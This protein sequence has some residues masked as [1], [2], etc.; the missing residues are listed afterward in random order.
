[1]KKSFYFV[2]VTLFFS[3]SAFAQTE[4][5]NFQGLARN[6]AGEVLVSQQISLRLSVLLG[7]ESGA[8]AYVETRLATTNPQGIFSL[9]VGDGNAISK[10][11]DFSSIDWGTASKFIKVEMDPNAGNNFLMMGTTRMQAV[12]FA[13]HA[14]GVDA[15]N[16]K[17][18]LPL[19]SG[20]TGVASISELKTSLALDQINNTSDASKPIS[21]ATQAALATKAN[22]SD[23]TNSL[24]TKVDKV[25]GK[26][27]STNDYTTAEKDKLAA[28]TGTNTGDQDLSG[29]ATTSDVT[30][31]LATKANTADVT[32]SLDTKV[33]KITGQGLSTNDYTTA[34]KDKLAA[35]TGT[36]TGD[37]VD[38][39]GNAGTAT[40]L[41]SSVTING[42][43]FD[44]SAN[45]T[46]PGG[47][48][49]SGAT[50]AVNLG[51]FDLTVNGITVGKGGGNDSRNTAIG[52]EALLN[53]SVEDGAVNNSANGYRA[54]KANIEGRGNTASGANAL[55]ANGWGNFN[56]ASGTEA[57]Q[58]TGGNSNTAIG[59]Q[60]GSY[61]ANGTTKNTTSDFSVY[62][63][64]NTKASSDNAQ[65]EVVI[66]YNAVGAGTNTI[67]LGNTAVT[68]VK[69]SGTLTAG[70]VTY[71]NT[72]GTSGQVLS[73][74]GTGTLS[75]TSSPAP[76]LTNYVTTNTAQT[77]T[78]SKIFSSSATA[79]NNLALGTIFSPTLT[80]AANNDILVGVDINPTFTNGTFTPV[81]NY[82]LR[83]QG[84]HIGRGGGNS[85]FNLA[86]GSG[87]LFRNTTGNTNVAI[88]NNSLSFN[89][90]G[91]NNTAIGNNTLTA[92]TVGD[93]N[94]AI[95]NNA[96]V[97]SNNLTNVTALGYG[98][99]VSTSNTIQ[100]GADGTFGTVAIT[101]VKTSGTLT[102]GT[103]TYPNAHN[104]ASGQVLT[105][106]DTGT[107]TWAAAVGGVPYT[108]AT[109]AVN[110]G[111]FDLTVNGITVGKGG[112][113]GS[114]NTA[115][116]FKALFSNQTGSMNTAIGNNAGSSFIG[117]DEDGNDLDE[118]NTTSDFSVYLGSNTKASADDAQNEVVIGYNAI[119][120]G[121]NT[122]RLG[123]TAIT[124]VITSGNLTVNGIKVGRGGGNL[125][126]NTALGRNAFFNNTTGE[127]N[128]ASGYASLLNNTTGS[129]NTAIG[130]YALRYNINGGE[131]T[132]IGFSALLRNT[133][134]SKNT[135]IGLGADVNSGSLT[136]ATAIG[137]GAVVN[138]DHT[139]QLGNTDVTD[140][141]TSGNLT[142]N[143]LTVGR[144]NGNIASNTA[145]GTSALNSNTTGDSNTAIGASALSSN[146]TGNFN[147]ASGNVALL[148]N[149]TGGQNT[150]TGEAALFLN[151]IGFYNSATGFSALRNNTTGDA[152]TAS[153]NSALQTNTTGSNNTAIGSLADVGSNNLTNAT[154]IGAGAVVNADNT[155]QLGADGTNNTT[156][157]SNVKTSGTL[158]AG[159][160]TYPNAHNNESG[161]VLTIDNAGTATWA[162]ATGGGVP[163]TGATQEVNLG[164]F[165]LTVNEIKVGKGGGNVAN[166][167]ALGYSA[168]MS[169]T[170]G[171]YNTASGHGSLASN[172]TG[173]N[174]TAI[175]YYALAY[176]EEGSN[177]IA[178]GSSALQSNKN[179]SGNTAIGNY[180]NVGFNN[181]TNATAIGYGARVS[182]SNT[183]QLGADGTTSD[184]NGY[185][186]AVTDVKT[187]GTITAGTVTYPNTV[188]GPGQVLATDGAG[189]VG[190]STPSTISIGAIA[191][192]SDV[193]GASITSGV[194]NLAPADETYGGVVT[195][196]TQTFAGDKTFNSEL[197]GNGLITGFNVEGFRLQNDNGF[198][199]GYSAD[200]NSRTGY[201]QFRNGYDVTLRAE[202]NNALNL[203]SAGQNTLVL[204][205]DQK[206]TLTGELNVIGGGSISSEGSI[207]G[208][209]LEGFR[210]QNQTGFLA[211]YSAD[212]N[213]RTGYLQF[214]SGFDVTLKAE[215]SNSLILGAAGFN[216]LVIGADQ[217][218]TL[219][220]DL[221]ANSFTTPS[222][223]RL[224]SNISP[225]AN[226]LATVMQLNPVHYMK[227]SSLASTAYTREE[228]GFI[229]QEI[230]KILPFIVKEGTDE[231][232]LL[233]VDYNSFI[234]MLTKAIQE[235]QKQIEDQNSKIAAQ[236]KQIEEL[237]K[238]VKGQ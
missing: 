5:I 25:T 3:L 86:V 30:T 208:L 229:A 109:Q 139:I 118:D 94:T 235:Q 162:A 120:D 220:G 204:G 225:L 62:L 179:G 79:T 59:N 101:N 40:K 45:I 68:D 78:A 157:I 173:G 102:A 233:S 214:R 48:P 41:Q 95:G 107:A 213:S 46:V 227:K 159:T 43:A 33:D 205:A 154:A 6:A 190:W 38:I 200:G 51:L 234:P 218:A 98:A 65:N 89:T 171:D 236:Q 181:L 130:N 226:S 99:R 124:D 1:M 119:G 22:A 61:I 47:V 192:T 75:W 106:D 91:N 146:T 128:T 126:T 140:V 13:F 144:G 217:T 134:G 60:A 231:N 180:T 87:A 100:L 216:T 114:T 193:N 52:F 93:F 127:N 58:F 201:L 29:Y 14:Y 50:Q 42:I 67:Q 161:Q 103:V 32:T 11:G 232:K 121:S 215:E 66:G 131:N 12:P 74:T 35:I 198:L 19:G 9:V 143:G 188:G 23:V 207:T 111:L 72:H 64:S 26:E 176:N 203:G 138:A 167:T 116:G 224:K 228:N 191:G 77:I 156:P 63:G 122:I 56:T 125:D 172:T 129:Y 83:V 44:G 81:A 132:A 209:N 149:T 212:G 55:S 85:S 18:I 197:K 53:N 2:F 84:I 73:T 16:V 105:I 97:A 187:S 71:P 82:G 76:D 7:S 70:A 54:L 27:L 69:T 160:V 4:G 24:A 80:A 123:N 113:N 194:L 17:G 169:N 184:V 135:A 153:G 202:Q 145:T 164:L 186:P 142:V 158:T 15:E 206:A 57:L 20:G 168:L 222:D 165:D 36:N 96:N 195:T 230:Q 133:T 136:N 49:Y 175:G 141:K 185:I 92:N 104:G 37:Q 170:T 155:I 31:S 117:Y 223:L 219:T 174:N 137:Y 189:V 182:A 152:N 221:I 183:I 210:L 151:T 108:G 28:I 115:I 90:V 178:I 199:A 177:N 112:G 39:T 163:Y 150:A 8:V 148:S 110:L 166:N 147:T 237:I 21:T 238:L 211:G 10:T 34:E 196:G 88:G